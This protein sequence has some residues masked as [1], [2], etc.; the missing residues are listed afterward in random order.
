VNVKTSIEDTGQGL[1]IRSGNRYL[2]SRY[3]PEKRPNLLATH[4]PLEHRCIYYIPSPLFGYGLRALAERIPEDSIILAIEISEKMM[5][6][7][8]RHIP[9]DIIEHPR[10]ILACLS[11][12]QALHALFYQLGPWKYRRIRRL[13]LN[14]GTELNPEIY[15]Q[16]SDFL[17]EDLSTYWRNRLATGRL[18]RQWIRHI[19]ANLAAMEKGGIDFRS[20]QHYH[21]AG[22]PVVVGAGPSLEK[23]LEFLRKWRSHLWI[24]A[25]DTAVSALSDACIRPDAISILETQSWNMLDLHGMKLT[26]IPLIADISAYPPSLEQTGG[27]CYTVS[28]SFAELE[29]LKRIAD[30]ELAPFPIPPLGS[31]GLASVE[32]ALNLRSDHLPLLLTGLDFAY[33]PGKSHSRGS[34][35]HRWQLAAI[36]R[37]NPQP[38]WEACMNRPRLYRSDARGKKLNTDSVLDGYASLFKDRYADLGR[39]FVLAP[40][41]LDLGVPIISLEDAERLLI[42][43][44]DIPNPVNTTPHHSQFSPVDYRGGA[45]QF[46]DDEENRL[47][48]IIESWDEYM[49]HGNN[50]S[51]LMESLSRMDQIYL[52]FPDEP[53]LPKNEHSFL[54]RAADRSRRLRRYIKRTRQVSTSLVRSTDRNAD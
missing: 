36:D 27:V 30:T 42:E 3:Q 28:S 53:P 45:S 33:Q 18:G 25:T 46:L 7:C 41:G 2:Y 40:A 26:E 5:A 35:S 4:A 10:L 52:D 9:N 13:D 39:L 44:P 38:G 20:F 43:T 17:L 50:E 21:I 19:Y 1:T 48:Q 15:N 54:V 14:G 31:V 6:L 34:S 16:L 37:L 8:S 49:I 12:R 22:I 32:I 47:K 29:F 51:A 23:S 24:L 11:D